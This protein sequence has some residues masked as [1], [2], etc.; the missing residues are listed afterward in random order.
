[1]AM[2]LFEVS[3]GISNYY[4]DFG[5]VLVNNNTDNV[6]IEYNTI[7]SH[8]TKDRHKT[9]ESYET[10]ESVDII[11]TKILKPL[12]YSYSAIKNHHFENESSEQKNII[13]CY[14]RLSSELPSLFESIPFHYDASIFVRVS[15]EKIN[16]HRYLIIG[17][18]NTPYENGCLI[19]DALMNENY[20]NDPPL[21][22]FK[23]TGGNRF[24][25]NL[26]SSGYVCLS[27]LGTWGGSSSEKWNE[28]TS[29]L[30]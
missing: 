19:F 3:S 27:L 24:N 15:S 8:E 23:N 13:K 21:F 28:I 10:K 29:N 20:P 4:K 5:N 6:S 11:Y 9:K 12:L 30:L 17:P 7:D 22:I 1:M 26:Y 14:K 25:P 16:M 18:K 2:N